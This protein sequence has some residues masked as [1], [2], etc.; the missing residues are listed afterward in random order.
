MKTT[1]AK[2]ACAQHLG[3]R[4]LDAAL[5]FP[6]TPQKRW[7][8]EK[9]SAAVVDRHEMDSGAT[10][11]LW[12]GSGWEFEAAKAASSRRGGTL[13]RSGL[14]IAGETAPRYEAEEEGGVKPPQSKVLRTDSSRG[15]V[16]AS[17]LRL[18][19]A[20]ILTTDHKG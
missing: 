7:R 6:C 4:R 3:L 2:L 8:F 10:T 11:R 17:G 12:L 9:G 5:E 13:T 15:T 1:R 20:M 19:R 14:M 18:E 16:R